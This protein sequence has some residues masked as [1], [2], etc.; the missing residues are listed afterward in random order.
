MGNKIK[1]LG[2]KVAAGTK[3]REDGFSMEV[4][5]WRE[6]KCDFEDK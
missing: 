2:R 1:G 5:G 6:E 4:E 3:K